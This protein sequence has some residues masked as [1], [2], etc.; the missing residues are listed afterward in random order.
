MATVSAKESEEQRKY[1]EVLAEVRRKVQAAVE[2]HAEAVLAGGSARD[3]AMLDGDL[4]SILLEAVE[5]GTRRLA[6]EQDD[7][8]RE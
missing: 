3:A 1:E 6:S 7:K 4:R 5:R 8:A 2:K